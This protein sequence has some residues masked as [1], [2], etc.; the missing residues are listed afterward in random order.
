MAPPGQSGMQ[1]GME[2]TTPSGRP[3]ST[4]AE[5]PRGSGSGGPAAMRFL[6]VEDETR[7]AEL[8]RLHLEG[9]GA[10]VR[11]SG[12]GREALELACGGG[13][14][15]L[16]LDLRLPGVGGLDICREMRARQQ[17]APILML[18]ARSTEIDRVLGLEIGADDYLT[19][20]FSPLELVAR[21][22]AL[23]RRAA[24]PVDRAAPGGDTVR[25]GDIEIDRERHSVTVRGRAVEL[26]AREF[27][28]RWF[29]ASHPG[30]VFRRSELLDAVWGYGHDGYEHTVNSHINRLRSKIERD[31]GRPAYLLTVWGVGYKFRDDP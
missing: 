3:G 9:L 31:P 22:K 21:C 1:H 30:R 10:S 19:K 7:I 27:E 12:D 13:W 5:R 25:R 26:T 18:T 8:V 4:V 15:L 11:I 16:V 20:P 23:L 2:S 29:V 24:A 6:V 28:L 17:H 14:D